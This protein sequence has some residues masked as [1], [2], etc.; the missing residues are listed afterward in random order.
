[1]V[2]VKSR[3]AET[4]PGEVKKSRQK[5]GP[6]ITAGTLA[7]IVGLSVFMLFGDSSRQLTGLFAVV[8][9]LLMMLA[10]IHIGLA[11]IAAGVIG[12]WSLGGVSMV[13]N[14]LE[15]AVYDPAATWELSVIPTFILMGTA[16]WKS[17]LTQRAFDAAK[18][19]LGKVPGGLALTTN[20]AGAGLAAT[21]GSTIA[22]THALGRVAIPEMLKAGYKPGIA[23]GAT[24]MAG[25]L[26]QIIP[27]SVM[28]V[29]YAGAAQTSVGKQLMAGIAPGILLAVLF[30]LF[31]LFRALRNPTLAPRIE[32]PSVPMID[33]LRGLAGVVPL[34]IVAVIVV[35]GIGSGI[36]TPTEA[37]AW[38]ALVSI[39]LGWAIRQ[40]HERTVKSFLIFCKEVFSLAVVSTAGIFL[41]LIGV[42]VLTRVMTLSR[43]ANGLAD[44][45]LTAG[46]T[47]TGFLLVLV[48]VY[49]ILGM[50]MDT[51]AI[52]LLTVPILAVPLT[53]LGVD[54]VWFGIFIVMMVEIAMVTPPMGILSFVLHRIV[55]DKDVNQGH[56]ISLPAVFAGSMPFVAVAI[57]FTVLLIFFPEI[58]MW[59]PNQLATGG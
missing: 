18:L 6:W 3:T 17:G 29:V 52:V 44:L 55:Q 1:M 35:G 28:L 51:M 14:S 24:A 15:H 25:T 46:L 37:A 56:K 57:G 40:G 32:G 36:F 33:K 41:L 47:A 23:V 11:M 21:S 22:L 39:V 34:M 5:L 49:L 26:G 59:L 8:L 50:F 12:L 13:A 43:L 2:L 10:G 16:L 9:V 42:H 31:I 19:W 48:L 53:E 7:V 30:G 54:L 38:G 58:V 45:V 27:P 20:V 4:G